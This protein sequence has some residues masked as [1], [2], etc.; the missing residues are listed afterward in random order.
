MILSTL[1]NQYGNAMK[2]PLH[3]RCKNKNKKK[4]LAFEHLNWSSKICLMKIKQDTCLLWIKGLW[5]SCLQFYKEA[6]NVCWTLLN[7]TEKLIQQW[8]RIFFPSLRWT[9]G[10]F[11][12]TCPLDRHKITHIT[13]LNSPNLKNDFVIMNWVSLQNECRSIFRKRL[14]QPNEERKLWLRL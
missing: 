3:Y 1:H 5:S 2:K 4:F 14:L 10:F 6:A 11:N 12:K 13:H 9:F 7:S 8:N